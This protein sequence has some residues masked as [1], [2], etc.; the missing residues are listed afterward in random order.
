MRSGAWFLGVVTRHYVSSHHAVLRRPVFEE[1]RVHCLVGPR[2][3]GL[4]WKYIHIYIQSKSSMTQLLTDNVYMYFCI[5]ISTILLLQLYT[6]LYIFCSFVS[7]FH[8]DL[9]IPVLAAVA[10]KFSAWDQLILSYLP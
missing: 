5:Y 7:D 2:P 10:H 9:L 1:G 3:G 6:L 8:F 4:Q